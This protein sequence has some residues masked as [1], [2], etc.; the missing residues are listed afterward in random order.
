MS[1]DVKSG[2]LSKSKGPADSGG[3]GGRGEDGG[4]GGWTVVPGWDLVDDKGNS[5]QVQEDG[6]GNHRIKGVDDDGKPFSVPAEHVP[7]HDVPGGGK[8]ESYEQKPIGH[9]L[10][11]N[12]P[13]SGDPTYWYGDADSVK[14]L[15]PA[16]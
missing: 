13:A 14:P 16:P 9:A 1:G 11:K 10:S 2:G 3:T 15:K 4:G 7:E 12:T 6:K 8:L 5:Y